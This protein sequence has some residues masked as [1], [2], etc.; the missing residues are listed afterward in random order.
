MRSLSRVAPVLLTLVLAGC[1]SPATTRLEDAARAA[2]EQGLA[3]A[4][5]GDHAGTWEVAAPVFKV[6][7]RKKDWEDR[8]AT[9]YRQLGKPDRRK[10]V[11]VKH[12]TSVPGLERGDYVVIQYRRPVWS[13][14]TVLETL[15]MQRAGEQWRPAMYNILPA[16][17]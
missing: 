7:I 2:A 17:Q 3:R 6:S 1:D 10:L 11:A 5:G 13:V 15:V 8:A 9:F 16:T 14:R 4:D 12:T